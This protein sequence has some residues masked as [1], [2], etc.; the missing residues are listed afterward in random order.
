M[1][2]RPIPLTCDCGMP[3]LRIKQVGLTP[4]HQIVLVWWCTNCKRNVQVVK[5]LADCWRECPPSVELE[6]VSKVKINE[7]TVRQSDADFLRRLGIR[8]PDGPE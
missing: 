2:F 4:Q 3:A 7:G 1:Q 8:L 5:D 6:P